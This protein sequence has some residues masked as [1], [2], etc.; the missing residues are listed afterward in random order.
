MNARKYL[1]LRIGAS[2]RLA[3]LRKANPDDW[4]N[5]RGW[6]LDNIAPAD[7][8]DL[9]Q[10]WNGENRWRTPVWYTFGEGHFRKERAAHDVLNSRHKGWFTD[11]DGRDTVHGIIGGL[12]HGKFLAGYHWNDNGETVW[13][14]DLFDCEREAARAADGHAEVFAEAAREHDERYQ[15]ARELEESIGDNIR[16]L[17]ECL[18]L[19]H[20]ECMAYVRREARDII[21]K[22]RDQREELKGYADVS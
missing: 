3:L 20:R 9:C 6:R 7:C 12:P 2:A 21:E 10:G 11:T 16:R 14:A 13:F 17:R 4:R 15:Q 19:R 5:A 1:N 22:I 8:R 18:A